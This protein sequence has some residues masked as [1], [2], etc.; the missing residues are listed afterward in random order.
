MKKD[1][2][3]HVRKKRSNLV[4]E[5]N[6]ILLHKDIARDFQRLEKRQKREL[7]KSFYDHDKNGYYESV[8][9]FS[10][11]EPRTAY[12]II[13]MLA[14][15]GVGC[16]TA[17]IYHA[18]VHLEVAGISL[19]APILVKIALIFPKA[20]FPKQTKVWIFILSLIL[21]FFYFCLLFNPRLP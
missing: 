12:I 5:P 20:K 13:G 19:I 11:I 6:N 10:G 7:M 18:N 21:G 2:C 9:G 14:C 15:L 4:S 8:Q 17:G 1:E 3:T 16:G